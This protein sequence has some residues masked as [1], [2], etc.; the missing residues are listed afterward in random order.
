MLSKDET[1]IGKISKQW[2]GLAKEIF[3][4]ADN[5]GV[6]FP[7]D[8]D[9]K[10]KATLMAAVFLIVSRRSCFVVLLQQRFVSRFN[11]AKSVLNQSLSKDPQRSHEDMFYFIL[12]M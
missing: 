7:M 2:S 6:S 3:T 5:F 4:D 11:Y 12:L 10:A 9:V 8:L 1:E